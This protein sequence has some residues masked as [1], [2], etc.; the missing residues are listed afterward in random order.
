MSQPIPSFCDLAV[1]GVRE[2]MPY[3]PGKPMAEL[4]REYGISDIVKLASNENPLGASPLAVAAAQRE[5]GQICRYPD[6]NGFDL[7]QALAAHHGLE[8]ERITLGNG[9]NDCL[10]LIARAFLGP[11]REALFS[12]HAFAVYPIATLAVGAS[13]VVA[14]ALGPEHEMA[15]G[16]DLEAMAQRIG[17]D[18]AVIFIANPNNPTGTWLKQAQLEAFLAR[19]PPRV[20]VVLDE[21]YVEYARD[22]DGYPDGSRWLERMPNLIVTRTFSKA[23]GLAGLRVGYALSHPQ[24]ADLLNRVRQPFN[25]NSPAQAAAVAG[26]E[27]QAFIEAAVALNATERGRMAAACAGLGLAVLPSAA[28]FICVEVGPRAA[29]IYEGLLR[30]GVIVRPVGGGYQL[31][32]HL[33]ISIGLTK[34]NDRCLGALTELKAL[35]L[36]AAGGARP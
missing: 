6:G 15:Y 25:V 9:S 28:N 12:A 5:L 29:E 11:G 14:P 19:V 33:R 18:T 32:R 3:Q 21:A 8:P 31:P 22:A 26:L 30:R 2:L 1:P 16:H 23:Y 7:K 24:V 10:D 13:S 27:D 35:D 20:I 17:P 36:L 34:E 4:E